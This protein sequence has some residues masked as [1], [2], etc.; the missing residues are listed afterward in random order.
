MFDSE[1]LAYHQPRAN[2]KLCREAV[3]ASKSLY[4]ACME[5]ATG[6]PELGLALV[7]IAIQF[8]TGEMGS[9]IESFNR[10]IE[11]LLTEAREG[12]TPA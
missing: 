12:Q 9:D 4:K 11:E 2:E 7:S 10:R 1:P 6:R 8:Q 5:L 3:E